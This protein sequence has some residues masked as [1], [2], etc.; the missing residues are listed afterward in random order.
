MSK[1]SQGPKPKEPRPPESIA[2]AKWILTSRTA[3]S[4]VLIYLIT[5]FSFALGAIYLISPYINSLVPI[6]VGGGAAATSGTVAAL[7]RRH[8]RNKNR[9]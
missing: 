1:K 8:K 3:A 4:W 6:L 9:D 7:Y 5:S 2:L